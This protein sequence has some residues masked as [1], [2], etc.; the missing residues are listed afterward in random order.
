MAF[1]L[2]NTGSGYLDRRLVFVVPIFPRQSEHEMSTDSDGDG[3]EAL[4]RVEVIFICVSPVEQTQGFIVDALHSELDPYIRSF[5][6]AL[7]QNDDFVGETVWA[8]RNRKP[9]NSFKIQ[10]A[11]K[12]SF[13]LGDRCIGIG[14]CLKVDDKF[15]DTL[16]PGRSYALAYLP[17]DRLDGMRL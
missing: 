10:S 14:R 1:N 9:D 3:F 6:E 15:F 16:S 11:S 17:G 13:E 12:M 4:Q 7:Q 8:G 5:R 2:V